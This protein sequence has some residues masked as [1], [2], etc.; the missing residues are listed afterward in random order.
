MDMAKTLVSRLSLLRAIV[1]GATALALVGPA[2]AQSRV[3]VTSATDGDPLG[4]PPTENERILRIGIDVQANEVV[5]THANDRAHLVFLD[6]TSLTVGPNARLTVDRFVYDPNSKTGEL[7]ITATQGVFRLVGG[8]ISKG[9]AITVNTPSSTIGIR[10]G[11]AIFNVSQLRT[12]ANFIFGHDMTVTGQ[13]LTRDITRPGSQV[14]VNSGASPS[15]PTLLPPGALNNL[16]STLETGANTATGGNADQKSQSSGYSAGNSGQQQNPPGTPP[17]TNAGNPPNT[18]NNSTTQAVSNSNGGSNPQDN[19]TS[20]Q[21]TPAPTPPTPKTTQT[22]SGYVGGL[23]VVST[24]GEGDLSVTAPLS[25]ARPG[26]LKIKT[27]ADSNTAKATII[28][29]GLDGSITSPSAKLKLGTGTHGISFFQNDLNFVTATIDGRATIRA[30]E[31]QIKAR[32]T[33]VLAT[34]ALLPGTYVGPGC[35]CDFLTFGEWATV[36]TPGRQRQGFLGGA[37]AVVAQAPWIAGSLATQ[38]PN[39]QSATFSGGMWGQAQNGNS[40]IR[41]VAGNFTLGYNWGQGSGAWN[42]NFDNRTYTGNVS[43]T[44]GVS[45]GNASIPATVGNRAMSVN[46]SFFTGAGAGGA[47]VGVGGQFGATGPG[48]LASGVFGGSKQ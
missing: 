12:I 16:I 19:T 13:G 21:P 8:K 36:I 6:G 20:T 44:G 45:F 22:L 42:S 28:I 14:I 41:N 4:K 47:V 2:A 3:G 37:N 46:G 17:G 38:L 18:N 5:T 40:A 35:T 9:N 33:S 1:L 27:N 29:R 15:L 30:G 34:A 11:I 32:D 24:G 25:G 23:I 26:D 10:G 7:A 43:S 31:A 48:Y 39:T